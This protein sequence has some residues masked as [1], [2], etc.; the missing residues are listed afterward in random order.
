[1][2]ISYLHGF[3]LSQKGQ[4]RNLKMRQHGTLLTTLY[5]IQTKYYQA[6]EGKCST[7]QWSHKNLNQ[8][9]C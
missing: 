2:S 7:Q 8:N 5:H 1:M 3:F 6:I 9:N 4:P